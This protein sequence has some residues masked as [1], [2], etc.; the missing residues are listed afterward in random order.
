MPASS[1]VLDPIQVS[2]DDDRVV[3]DAGLM[4]AG[5]LIGRLGLEALID[6]RV[7]RGY[8]PGRKLLTIT[9]TLLSGGDCID[10]IGLLHAGV[11]GKVLG[12]GTV[13][14]STAGTWLRSLTFGHIRQ[15]DAVT[16]TALSRA[17]RAG[18]GP[19]NAPMFIDLDSTVCEV[20]S[21]AKQGAGYGYTR[22]LGLHP[23]L[24][25]RAD[26]GEVLH[27]RMRKGSAGSSRGAQRFVR[28]TIGRVRR[29]GATGKLTLRADSAFWSAKVINACV[30]HGI[31]FS[32]AVRRTTKTVAAID[33]IDPDDWV[34]I[35]YTAGGS[36]QV[37]EAT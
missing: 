10:D 1:Q 15:L 13:A 24:A 26:T 29:A 9:S 16:E 14:A 11:T 37:A 34:D 2:F 12:H 5:T 20:H 33:Q 23:L 35:A 8:R 3:V 21:D 19:G 32:I 7:S 36:A 6:D 22:Q 31:E 25:T 4:L 28:E 30:D 27:A 17:W 18:A